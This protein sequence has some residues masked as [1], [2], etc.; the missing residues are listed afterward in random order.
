[1]VRGL[2]QNKK[3]KN[4]EGITTQCSCSKACTESQKPIL[5]HAVDKV[6]EEDGS[7]SSNTGNEFSNFGS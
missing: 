7:D 3:K 1:M 5:F 4:L 6:M 2:D